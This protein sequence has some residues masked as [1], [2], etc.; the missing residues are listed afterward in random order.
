[1]VYALAMPI[2]SKQTESGIPVVAISGR[3]TFGR[4]SERLESVV[5]DL[6]K[7]G[8]NRLVFDLSALEYADSSGIGAIVSCVTQ[9]R[10]SGSNLG[11]AGV[12]PRIQRLFKMTGVDQLLS[13]Y[14]T[15]AEAV[16]G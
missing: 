15:V 11:M 1:M 13:L 5:N 3:L 7:Q 12:N 14:P 8:R 10:K 6:L 16:A 2:E 4:E 9:I